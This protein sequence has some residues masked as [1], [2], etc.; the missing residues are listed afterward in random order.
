MAPVEPGEARHVL[1][2]EARLALDDREQAL[3]QPPPLG[4]HRLVLALELLDRGG[5]LGAALRRRAHAQ[6][7]EEVLVFVLVVV[8]A[9]GVEVAQDS[10]RV[11]AGPGVAT[12][13]LEV[14]HQPLE[15][16]ELLLDALVARRERL[17]RLIELRAG[18][19]RHRLAVPF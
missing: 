1:G 8:D 10:L 12:V 11:G 13:G 17:E 2:S 15:R 16:G 18:I 6:Q 4:V 9:G 3:P 14:R 5:D 19:L 7:R